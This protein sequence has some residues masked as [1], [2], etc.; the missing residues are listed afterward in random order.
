MNVLICLLDSCPYVFGSK[1]IYHDFF[2]QCLPLFRLFHQP[3]AYRWPEFGLFPRWLDF[4]IKV[5]G[6]G[7]AGPQ[8]KG[9]GY[10]FFKV[11]TVLFIF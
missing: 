10:F 1:S 7:L 11:W 5:S 8:N 3:L 6:V 9:K 4:K 2:S